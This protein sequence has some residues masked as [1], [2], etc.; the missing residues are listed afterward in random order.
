FEKS[1]FD[2][3][4]KTTSEGFTMTYDGVNYITNKKLDADVTMAM[5]LD[6]FLFTFKDNKVKVNDFAM[7]FAGTILM[8]ETDIDLDLTFKALDTDF[9]TILSLVPGMYTESFKDVKTD[10]KLAFNGYVKGRF[11]ETSMPGFGTDLKVTN[12]MFKY[13]DLPQAATNINVDMSVDNKDGIINN[14]NVEVRKFHLDLGK[15][16]VD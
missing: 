4:S 9:K 16:P 10:G 8:P 6:K 2:M 3:V 12:A 15:N 13:P 7:D 5:D 14:T 11:N 1:V